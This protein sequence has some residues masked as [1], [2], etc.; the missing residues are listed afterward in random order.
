MT[1]RRTKTN[2]VNKLFVYRS[3]EENERRIDQLHSHSLFSFDELYSRSFFDEFR[4]QLHLIMINNDNESSTNTVTMQSNQSS[5]SSSNETNP[6]MSSSTTNVTESKAMTDDQTVQN[7]TLDNEQQDD[8][9]FI[10]ITAAHQ[11]LTEGQKKILRSIQRIFI[12]FSSNL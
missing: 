9:E 4:L 10:R 11:I 6:E 5:S 8:D 3:S 2:S 12:S 1:E 7:A